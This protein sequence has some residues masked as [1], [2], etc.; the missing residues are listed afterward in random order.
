MP[1]AE[2]PTTIALH[3]SETNLEVLVPGGLSTFDL[4]AEDDDNAAEVYLHQGDLHLAHTMKLSISYD[5]QKIDD[6][7][8]A[9]YLHQCSQYLN[10]YELMLL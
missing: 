4:N 10:D 3:F 1:I 8:A 5:I 9:E 7:T 6:Q 2:H